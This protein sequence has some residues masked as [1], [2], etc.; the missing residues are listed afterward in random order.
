MKKSNSFGTTDISFGVEKKHKKRQKAVCMYCW[1]LCLFLLTL[2][3]KK[4]DQMSYGSSRAF[5]SLYHKK[6][7]H[8]KLNYFYLFSFRLL[9][10]ILS[11]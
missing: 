10:R 11:C 5:N 1:R 7:D 2:H 9:S 6:T 4:L 8:S 3:S